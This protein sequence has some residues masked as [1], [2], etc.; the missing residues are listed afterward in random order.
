MGD[1]LSE[2]YNKKVQISDQAYS[3]QEARDWLRQRPK[4]A[5]QVPVIDTEGD[6]ARDEEPAP[7]PPRVKTDDS[8]GRT[9]GEEGT[10]GKVMRH[11]A[12]IP[13]QTLA[14]VDDAARHALGFLDPLT[15]W[16]NEHVADLRY[17]S[18]G[19]ATTGTGAVTRK[20]SEFL[21]GF[22]PIM[23]GLKYAGLVNKV[24]RPLIAG[25]LTDFAVHDPSEGRLSDLWNELD[26]PRNVLTDYLSS[27]PTDTGMEARFKNALESAGLGAMFEGVFMGARAIRALRQA[28]KSVPEVGK[29][30]EEYLRAKYGTVEE[31]ATAEQGGLTKVVHEGYEGGE[32]GT[33]TLVAPKGKK[34]KWKVKYDETLTGESETTEF[35]TKAQAQKH[36]D[37]VHAQIKEDIE[38]GDAGE[39]SVLSVEREVNQK[40]ATSNLNNTYNKVVGDPSRPAIEISVRK[41]H[42]AGKKLIHADEATPDIAP[43]ALI[44]GKKG[45]SLPEDWDVYINFAAIDSP[46][47]VK[48]AIG[49]MAEAMKGHIDEA[50]RGVITQRETDEL[51]EQL[52]M[53]PTDLLARRRGQAF[54]AEEAVAARNIW[55][56]S[57]DELV[58]SAERAAAPNAG[59]L[60][61]FAF[62]RQMAIHAAVQNEVLGARA[63]AGRALNSWKIEAK[64]GIER[65][66]AIQQVMN[67]MGGPEA[68]AEM[69]KRIAI[70]ANT[71]DPSAL[72]RI[73]QQ[74][75]AASSVQA[76]RELWINGLLASPKTHMVNITSNTLVAAQQ[77]YERAAASAIRSVTGGEGV[78]PGEAL[79]MTHGLIEG[80]KDGFR[81]AAKAL[82]T[83]ESGYAFNK[84]DLAQR[85]NAISAEAFRMS[86]ET[87]IGRFLDFLGTGVNIPGRLLTAEDE[88]FRSVGYRMNVRAE[89]LRLA[90]QE[91]HAG[92]ALGRRYKE[93]VDNPTESIRI[94]AADAA[95]M[96]TFTNEPGAFGKAIMGLRN[97]GGSNNWMNPAFLVLPFVRTPVNIARYAFERS[98]FAPLVSQWRADI[99]AGGARA[100]L[101][102]ARMSTGTAIMLTAMDL[103]DKGL[104][105]GDGPRGA[106]KELRESMMRQGWQ[107]YSAK[108]GDRWYSYNRLDPM[109]MTFGFA[110]SIAE[111]VKKGELD[112]DDVDE[113]WEVTAM[114]I[115]AVSQVTISKTYLEGFSKM[116]EVL[117]DPKRYSRQYVED[118]MASFVPATSLNAAVKNIVDPVQREAGSPAEAVMARIAGLSHMLPPR[119]DLWGRE[120]TSES[121]LG[122]AYDFMAPVASKPEEDSP[123]D[124][125]IVRHGQGPDRI[126]KNTPFDGVQ[127]NM[128]FYPKAYDD[129]VRL[130]G[131]DLK[132]PAWG[133]G[134][135]DYLDAVVSGRHPMSASYNMM[136]DESQQAFIQ[137][138]VQEYRKLAQR[139]ILN[140]PKHAA[141]AQE[142]AR[143]KEIHRDT[144]LPVM[145]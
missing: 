105:S 72:A 19:A 65:A 22:I 118:L 54:N 103:A 10:T 95:L 121:G 130:S 24:A 96:Q 57:G 129:Y 85:P 45:S 90:T 31:G 40:A 138:T 64:G 115:A 70:L 39:G 81:M 144:K 139:E 51:A 83:G 79:A 134:A 63:E 37:E 9:E 25:S 49:K 120:I 133:M 67:A 29:S 74:G 27:K 119:R 128:R 58:K 124:R 86:K 12:E 3:A 44:R 107:P 73:A 122:K 42:P 82:K 113:W 33:Y 52:G 84:I 142:V 15:D 66:R 5:E 34:G 41:P 101:A 53:T 61:Q 131:N 35:A 13:K 141:F 11:V 99:A 89:A 77:I 104:V 125:E 76:F 112:H 110:A 17:D 92:E 36:L 100:D 7:R 48:F 108:I 56:A 145:E 2:D 30:E 117:G 38:S 93:L 55:V 88:F 80:I 47:K 102:L 136:S 114:S 143:L 78:V 21:T 26:L 60:D 18:F 16:L 135:K 43:R 91:G 14:G 75:Y 97:A 87:M 20:L 111:A 32:S 4:Q 71:G 68:S 23:K 28:G 50:K 62:R 109:G 140:D 116:V 94:D 127:A 59:A 137:Q 132:H 98:P 106:D 123:V 1:D 46:D 6:P 126:N 8:L 69:A